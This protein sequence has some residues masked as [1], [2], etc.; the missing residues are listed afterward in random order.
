M[1]D[2]EKAF[3]DFVESDEYDRI[4]TEEYERLRDILFAAL[5]NGYKAGWVAAGGKL[6]EDYA[7][8][9]TGTA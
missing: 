2:F 5:R 6:P 7:S 1:L 4:E 3:G 9:E 8:G